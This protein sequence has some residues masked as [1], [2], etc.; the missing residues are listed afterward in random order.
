MTTARCCL[1]LA[2]CLALPTAWSPAE[3]Q[4]AGTTPHTIPTPTGETPQGVIVPPSGIDPG[5]KI[6]TPRIPAR[7]TPII[8]PPRQAADGKTVVV[9]R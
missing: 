6:R 2:G 7:S 3:A 1:L 8:R 9:P 4:T 5:M